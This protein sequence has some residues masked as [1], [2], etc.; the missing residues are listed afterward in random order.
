M[1]ANGIRY[2]F[3]L[4]ALSLAALAAADLRSDLSGAGIRALVPGDDGYATA[5]SANN[6]RFNF[7]PA[8]IAYPNTADDVSKIVTI[9][10]ANGVS[11]VARSSGHS[12]IANGLG[13]RDGALVIDMSNMTEIS[14]DESSGI[15]IIKTGNILGNVAIGLNGNGRALPHGICPYVGIG[16]HSGA[17][18]ARMALILSVDSYLLSN[19]SAFGGWGFT[20]RMWG[21]TLDTIK[22]VNTVLSNGTIA[23]VTTDNYPD[24]FWAIRGSAPSFGIT[25]SIEVET[26]P[27]PQHATIYAYSWNLTPQAAGRAFVDFQSFVLNTADLPP[28][29]GSTLNLRRGNVSGEVTF[30]LGGGWYAEPERLDGV[31]KPF[32]DKLPV[33]VSQIRQGNGTWID[34]VDAVARLTGSSLESLANMPSPQELFYSKSLMTPEGA[35]VTLE[36]A[37]ALMEYLS[38]EGFQSNFDWTIDL[39]LFGG[40]NSMVNAVNPESTS[41]VRRDTLFTWDIHAVASNDSTFFPEDSF[42]FVDGVYNTVVQSMPSDWNYSAYINYIDDRLEDWQQRYY[43]GHY[44]RL[45]SIKQDMDPRD[46]FAFPTSIEELT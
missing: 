44:N 42:T 35:P 34:S 20:S 7:S 17:F 40:R 33:S 26:M 30:S 8:A 43:G 16:G 22:A 9:G 32:I 24:L 45:Q 1:S 10:A 12:F 41:F 23:H 28:Q 3:V 21:L 39:L 36:A 46:V 13:G 11:V 18:S 19:L 15:A 27:A 38:N 31:L 14:V 37:V 2:A 4:I 5:S 29:L 6:R 25:T